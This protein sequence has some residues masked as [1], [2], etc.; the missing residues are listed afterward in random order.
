MFLAQ[1]TTIFP[2]HNAI[3]FWRAFA[4]GRGYTFHQ[5]KKNKKQKTTTKNNSK[6]A[7]LKLIDP[8]F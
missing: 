3:M 8:T 4:N 1:K 2:T 7:F 6:S 5:E